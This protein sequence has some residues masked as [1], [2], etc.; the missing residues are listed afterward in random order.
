M[1]HGESLFYSPG[2]VAVVQQGRLIQW[3]QL[4]WERFW[5]KRNHSSLLSSVCIQSEFSGSRHSYSILHLIRLLLLISFQ[6][7][8][9]VS[10]SLLLVLFFYL[11]AHTLFLFI[12][13]F[14]IPSVQQFVNLSCKAYWLALGLHRVFFINHD[15]S[16]STEGCNMQ[17]NTLTLNPLLCS[18]NIVTQDSG[19]PVNVSDG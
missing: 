8:L 15:C 5:W 10:P 16:I 11:F 14:I 7:F 13:L 19:H 12:T 9:L 18:V 2:L 6:C 4:H 1:Y 17:V 3:Q